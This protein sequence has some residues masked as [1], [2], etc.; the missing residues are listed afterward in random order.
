MSNEAHGEERL[1][2][3]RLAIH[4]AV[5]GVGFRPFVY[6]CALEAKL[7]GWVFN[8]PDGV[9][10]EVEGRRASL[11]TFHTRILNEHPRVARILA[12]S[13]DW[14]EPVGFHGFQIR[15]SDAEGLL[16]V[17]VLPDLATCPQCRS[18]V[19]DP[20]N[21][22]YRYPL[23]NCTQCGPRFS[24]IEQ[25]PY[26]RPSTTMRS[27]EL[28]PA[29]RAEYEDP[30]NRR[31][32]AQPNACHVCGPQLALWRMPDGE[33]GAESA[34]SAPDRHNGACM[35]T[36]ATV[37]AEG[38]AALRGAIAAILAGQIV[39]VKGLGGF[40]LICDARNEQAVARLRARKQRPT[41]PL[42]LMVRDLA[43]AETLCLVPQE[44][45][46]LLTSPEA[47]IVLLRRRD[48]A[49]VAPG[50][51][52]GNPYLGLMLP[53]TPLHHLLLDAL[54]AP[55]V[56]T[57]GNLTDEPIA[58]D[59]YEALQ[60]LTGIA[61]WLLVHNRPLVRPADDS[62]A[63]L[64][65]GEPRLLRRARGYAPAPVILQHPAPSILALGA[66][67]KN[68]IALSVG[69]QVLL[70][71]HL[72][73]L[74]TPE[75]RTVFGQVVADLMRLYAATPT[76]IVHDLHPDYFTTTFV[77]R[78]G[79]GVLPESAQVLSVQH[80]HA[81][82]ASC[83]TE[84]QVEGLALGIIWDGTGYGLDGTIWG[85]EFLY[86]NVAYSQRVAHLRPFL[87]PGGD[88]AIREPRRTALALLYAIDGVQAMEWDD[89][90]PLQTF[91]AHERVVFSRM[92]QTGAQC[93]PT[94]SAGRLFDGVASLL[95]LCQKV[96][97]EGEAAMMLEY[98]AD[99]YETVSYPFMLVGSSLD[100]RPTLIALLADLRRGVAIERI[101]ARFHNAMVSS[102]VAV[103][104]MIN[105][106]V[107]VL[108]GGCFQ[109]RLLAERAVAVLGACGMRTL[110]HRQVP[111]N[112]GG[113]SL[114][115]LA[116]AAARIEGY[117][118]TEVVRIARSYTFV[119]GME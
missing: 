77:Q 60:R 72:G 45:A 106:P 28:C 82:L 21:R 116:A 40:Q 26:D 92:F 112:D 87:L 12:A 69:R 25:L 48:E 78:R 109:N 103:A 90:A 50:I 29:C 22:R 74:A 100:W 76:A 97:F 84:H 101:S 7:T 88:A 42:A 34:P 44:A 63:M 19:R 67:L 91:T 53:T 114:G 89:L 37:L 24:I 113:I 108:S 56:A 94:S 80:H 6:R 35:P 75:A 85:G 117:T 71:Q 70:S 64:L 2:R 16:S 111:P 99:P 9:V 65:G 13:V 18:E 33:G 49:G 55:V 27:F 17:Q 93:V 58:I 46:D 68:T 104:R 36:S 86:G 14:L 8:G 23:T 5:Q 119:P 62:V 59:E 41:K 3:L 79:D 61:D 83:M 43:M 38:D 105:P 115:Q 110:L 95:G 98:V 52:P 20:A 39:G 57:S 73:D 118:L 4:G 81:H 32:H 11:E 10:I 102:M 66:Q 107:I 54:E 31:F 30:A 47:P 1:I 51:A 96:T 15:E